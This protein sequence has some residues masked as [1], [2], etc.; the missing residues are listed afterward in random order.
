MRRR[1]MRMNEG[2]VKKKKKTSFPSMAQ[3]RM[4][5]KRPKERGWVSLV[6]PIHNNLPYTINSFPSLLPPE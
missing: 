5:S 2:R 1:S 4:R 3:K 6:F